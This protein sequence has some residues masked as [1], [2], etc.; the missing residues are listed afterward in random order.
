M[1]NIPTVTIAMVGPTGVGKTSLLAAMY[2]ELETELRDIGGSFTMEAGPTQKSINDRIRELKSICRSDADKSIE[3]KAAGIEGTSDMREYNFD[4]DVGDGGEPEARMRFIDLPGGWYT[5]DGEYNKA[6]QIL[7]GSHVS[8]LAVDAVALMEKNGKYHEDINRT[9]DIKEAYKRALKNIREDHIVIITLI[10]SETYVK[11]NRIPELMKRVK[12]EYAELVGFL[13]KN[14]EQILAFACYVETVGGVRFSSVHERNGKPV[15]TYERTSHGYSPSRCAIPLRIAANRALGEALG[16]EIEKLEE[17]E[18]E[19]DQWVETF[20]EK[21]DFFR[22]F[23]EE[24]LGIPTSREE[25]RK[26]ANAAIEKHEEIR[27]KAL[28]INETFESLSE[29]INESDYIEIHE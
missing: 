20:K 16:G 4:L 2:R 23:A 24:I 5:G 9:D 27:Q 6:D 29:K 14:G 8:F 26:K 7:A 12:E 10:R 17:V 11:S 28:K 15:F 18:R 3:I 19:A 21:D 25:A 13:K 22:G 1:S